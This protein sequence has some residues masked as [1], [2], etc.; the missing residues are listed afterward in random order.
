MQQIFSATERVDQLLN[1][2]LAGGDVGTGGASELAAALSSLG[3]QLTV[4]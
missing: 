2:M 3:V 4:N 1:G